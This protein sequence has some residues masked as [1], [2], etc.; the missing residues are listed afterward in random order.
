MGKYPVIA[1]AGFLL[2]AIVLGLA[3]PTV[4]QKSPSSNE[5]ADDIAVDAVRI[6]DD[7]CIINAYER[8]YFD[9]AMGRLAQRKLK[10]DEYAKI[11]PEEGTPDDFYDVPV[12]K[13]TAHIFIGHVFYDKGH[14]CIVGLK[15][16]EKSAMQQWLNLYRLKYSH[17]N[18]LDRDRRAPYYFANTGH[19]EKVLV[20]IGRLDNGFMI[21]Y[22]FFE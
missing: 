6:F 2:V 11:L 8:S 10:H 19:N 21:Y 7:L 22:S 20:Q 14:N 12:L 16:S 3:T 9:A 17:A 13:D 1:I 4:A 15:V 18:K 5:I